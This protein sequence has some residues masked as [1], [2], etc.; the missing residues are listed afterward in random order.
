MTDATISLDPFKPLDKY[1]VNVE[2][3]NRRKQNLF[4]TIKNNDNV[5]SQDKV[6]DEQIRS[7][8]T[9]HRKSTS[10]L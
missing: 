8:T 10:M 7:K 3:Q 9:K 2:L 4:S 5:S 6:S 1:I